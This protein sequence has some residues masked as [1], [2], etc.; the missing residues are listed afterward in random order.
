MLLLMF[1]PHLDSEWDKW[2]GSGFCFQ[3]GSN[4]F[5]CLKPPLTQQEENVSSQAGEE[6]LREVRRRCSI[7]TVALAVSLSPVFVSVSCL[8]LSLSVLLTCV[9]VSRSH[10]TVRCPPWH[11]PRSGASSGGRGSMSGGFTR[12]HHHLQ[13]GV[14]RLPWRGRWLLSG[15]ST[16]VVLYD[17]DQTRQTG[18]LLCVEILL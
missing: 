18:S 10:L 1:W 6:K 17:P 4:P 15:K 5:V 16:S 9:S 2:L 14:R 13:H 12:V 8:S 3:S 11:S 7:Q